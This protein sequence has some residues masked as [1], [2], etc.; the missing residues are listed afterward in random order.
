MRNAYQSVNN[1]GDNDAW[2][3][4]FD[5]SKSGDASLLY[6]TYLGGPEF[7]IA[8]DVATEGGFAYVVGEAG[9]GFPTTANARVRTISASRSG[10]VAKINTNASGAASLVWSTYTASSPE[11]S[12]SAVALLGNVPY[13]TGTA[14]CCGFPTTPGAFQTTQKSCATQPCDDVWVAKFSTDG[15]AFQY[16]TVLSGSQEEGVHDIAVDGAGVAWLTGSTASSDYPVTSDAFQ[17]QYHPATCPTFDHVCYDAFLTGVKASGSSLAYSTYLGNVGDDH[18]LGI[19]LRS[20]FAYVSGFTSSTAFPTTSGAYKRTKSGRTDAFIAKFSTYPN[21]S[22]PTT[23]RTIHLCSPVNGSTV[24][25]PVHVQATAKAG[26]SAIKSMQIY[27]DGVKKYDMPNSSKIDTS[28]VMSAA[29][30]RVTVQA[31]DSSGAFKTTVNIT[32]K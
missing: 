19:A 5:P 16:S 22:T 23:S 4:K 12:A 3:A 20:G 29:A 26:S 28:I 14:Q 13:V 24:K 30:H 25:S 18:G 7:D 31:I 10:F 8:N 9:A 2:L 6:A 32:V 15:S 1:G 21:C 17:R 11:N 27:L